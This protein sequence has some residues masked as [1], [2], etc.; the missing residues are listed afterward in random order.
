MSDSAHTVPDYDYLLKLEYWPKKDAAL[1][2]CGKDPE[3]YRGM[4]FS[5]KNITEELIPAYKLYK[6][7]DSYDK[8]SNH[9]ERLGKPWTYLSLAHNKDWEIPD[10][11]C[12]AYSKYTVRKNEIA[13]AAEQR[14]Q[15]AKEAEYDNGARERKYLLKIIGA[16]AEL[17]TA[18]EI[19]DHVPF[20][21]RQIVVSHVVEALLQLKE[22][23]NLQI[24][25]L[26]KSNLH[27]KISE[28]LEALWE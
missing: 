10:A 9:Q 21:E 28:G 23:H 3:Y 4:Q 27:K 5:S 8:Y 1:I 19:P 25:G 13:A 24:T 20:A 16:L 22:D 2:I 7:F 12:E 6:I 11:L 17:Y 14:V 26:G 15:E 18:K